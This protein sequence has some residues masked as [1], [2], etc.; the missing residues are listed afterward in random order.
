MIN[1]DKAFNGF[2]IKSSKEKKEILLNLLEKMLIYKP[3]LSSLISVIQKISEIYDDKY[4]FILDNSYK[5]ILD[6]IK[7]IDEIS[8]KESI[9]AFEKTKYFLKE[10]S[11]NELNEY[12]VTEKDLDDILSK[13]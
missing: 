8:E 10:I 12:K 9:E 2:K 6:S 5:I 1:K 3:E 13:I 11:Y 7:K 4:V